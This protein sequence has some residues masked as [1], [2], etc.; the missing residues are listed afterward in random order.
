MSPS[1]TRSAWPDLAAPLPSTTAA[2][3]RVGNHDQL[4]TR[5]HAP[6]PAVMTELREACERGEVGTLKAKRGQLAPTIEQFGGLGLY[7]RTGYLESA[8]TITLSRSI[9]DVV[10][11]VSRPGVFQRA[12]ERIVPEFGHASVD[13]AALLKALDGLID[14]NT[15]YGLRT[16]VVLDESVGFEDH[17]SLAKLA[18]RRVVG[19]ARAVESDD[20]PVR[21]EWHPDGR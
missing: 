16:L 14:R 21:P 5:E 17:A 15:A 7:A 8:T 2:E 18:K 9:R 19:I 20:G 1:K 12:A 4:E 11:N 3:P 13:D 10:V 6:E